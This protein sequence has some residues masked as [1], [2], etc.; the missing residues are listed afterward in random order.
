MRKL[1]KLVLMSAALAALAVGGAAFAQAQSAGTVAKVTVQHSKGETSAPGDSDGVQSGDQ[2]ESDQGS[3]AGERGSGA[4]SQTE[5]PDSASKSD[6]PDGH[7]DESGSTGAVHES[8]G[9]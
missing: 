2:N 8:E 3:Q 5:A 6:G 4:E 9:D 7:H 1:K